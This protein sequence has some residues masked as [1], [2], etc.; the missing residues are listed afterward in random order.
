LFTKI[1]IF[2][3][4]LYSNKVSKNFIK[5]LDDPLKYQKALQKELEIQY[6]K[7]IRFKKNE[8]PFDR[9]PVV[10]YDD[11]SEYLEGELFKE[12][13]ICFEETSGSS[14]QS[15]RIPY[16]SK[17]L[18]SFSR[19]F[20]IWSN[21]ILNSIQ[22]DSYKFYFSITPQFGN[23]EKSGLEDDSE[24]MG[25][26]LSF[27]SGRYFVQIPEVKSIKNSEEFL[28]QLSLV[29]ISNRKLEIIS[30]WS[31]TYMLTLLSF[32]TNNF[33]DINKYLSNGNYRNLKFDK[34]ELRD[35]S[36]G[37][38]FPSLK[39]ISSWGSASARKEFLELK[40]IFRD[41]VVQEK[42]LLAT[43]APMTI[44][45]MGLEGG[46]PLI[47]EVY[48]EFFDEEDNRFN[49][50]QVE[51][52]NSYRLVISQKAGF[53]RYNIKD[54]VK[55]VGFYKKTPLLEFVGRRDA[56]SDMFGEKV[57]ELDV[58]LAISNT[59]IRCLIPSKKDKCYVVV[60][61]SNKNFSSDDT[62]RKIEEVLCKNIHYKNSRNLKQL[63][64]LEILFIKD[65]ERKI[66]QFHQEQFSISAGDLKVSSL[67]FREADALITYLKAS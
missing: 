11:L 24:Y 16:N 65:L 56:I 20:I 38:L 10:E 64:N 57:H 60:A 27:F 34:L 42:G 44:P 58:Q 31:P 21:D 30:I 63:N 18:K 41:I 26:V 59:D 15:K 29:L 50:S 53:L 46:V 54:C 37:T 52:G 25:G 4:K 7:S 3:F 2:F 6:E 17:I 22:F 45:L 61:D 33:K 8:I 13:I 14:G 66:I 47:D 35:D 28:M 32:I 55:V 5:K 23:E 48:F 62:L 12:K 49:I 51:K 43:E 19:M 1:I 9:L 67:Y 36:V 39:Y 40:E